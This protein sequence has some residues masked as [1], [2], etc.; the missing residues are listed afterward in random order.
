MAEPA[1][2]ALE[3]V[4]AWLDEEIHWPEGPQTGT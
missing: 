1:L 2:Q 4:H 3:A